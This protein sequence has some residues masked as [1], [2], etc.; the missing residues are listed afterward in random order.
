MI[1]RIRKKDSSDIKKLLGL[2]RKV[3]SAIVTLDTS[4]KFADLPVLESGGIDSGY[5]PCSAGD[6][7]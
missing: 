2:L 6:C 5:I 4:F 7:A 1:T 3:S